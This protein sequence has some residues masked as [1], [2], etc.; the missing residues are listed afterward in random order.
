[1][2]HH[3][4]HVL[5][6]ICMKLCT[7]TSLSN[8]RARH[9]VCYVRHACFFVW[10]IAC[11]AS[12]MGALDCREQVKGAYILASYRYDELGKY[13]TVLDSIY[14]RKAKKLYANCDGVLNAITQFQQDLHQAEKRIK[15]RNDVRMI[16]YPYLQPG[17]VP[18][19]INV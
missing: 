2:Q 3:C 9:A 17:K 11:A 5:L 8:H 15:R 6:V 7:A 10:Q 1:M 16:K 18:N 4:C 12:D 19:S 13:D 14:D